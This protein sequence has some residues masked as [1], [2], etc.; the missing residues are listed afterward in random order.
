MSLPEPHHMVSPDPLYHDYQASSSLL[1][2]IAALQAGDDVKQGDMVYQCP[3]HGEQPGD[4]MGGSGVQ[5]G[6]E[7]KLY[8]PM[9]DTVL[10]PH[11]LHGRQ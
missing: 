11:T 7:A 2:L 9:G 5:A 8:A 10:M 6:V 4:R 3:F 1:G